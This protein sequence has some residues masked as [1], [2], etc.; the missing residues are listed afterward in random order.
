MVIVAV[1][2]IA[3]LVLHHDAGGD[4]SKEMPLDMYEMC[5]DAFGR[6]GHLP[7]VQRVLEDMITARVSPSV[8]TVA[9]AFH[10]TW[11]QAMH[12]LV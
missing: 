10:V 3:V 12:A 5:L 9:G 4:A 11:T 7:S 8:L 6:A 2:H 1:L